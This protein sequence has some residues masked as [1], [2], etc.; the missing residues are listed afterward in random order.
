MFTKADISGTMFL[1]GVHA[2]W[3]DYVT[4]YV[5]YRIC[6]AIMRTKAPSAS[7]KLGKKS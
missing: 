5:Q 4:F 6:N 7:F 2:Y 1:K 3:P